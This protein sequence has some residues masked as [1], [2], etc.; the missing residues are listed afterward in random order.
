MDEKAIRTQSA[1]S[2]KTP[3]PFL[4]LIK[5]AFSARM[6]LIRAENAV[7]ARSAQVCW[8]LGLAR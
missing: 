7:G 5:T 8:R 2:N 6:F 4:V 1:I 3:E